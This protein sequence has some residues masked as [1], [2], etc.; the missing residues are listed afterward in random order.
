[1]ILHD[2]ISI[3]LAVPVLM[4]FLGSALA[5][6]PQCTPESGVAITRLGQNSRLFVSS[7]FHN[8]NQMPGV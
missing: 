1:M 5:A 7:N 2:K 3:Y 8:Q 6:A 4:F